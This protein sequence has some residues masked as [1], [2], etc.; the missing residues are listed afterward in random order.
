MSVAREAADLYRRLA[1]ESPARFEHGFALS[2]NNLSVSFA[3]RGDLANSIVSIR[4][5]VD[6]RRRLA[7]ENPARFGSDLVVSLAN[8]E[9]RLR[10]N[11]DEQG[12]EAA[13]REAA[14]FRAQCCGGLH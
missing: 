2:L 13:A 10:D 4:E 11:G 7:L 6:I 8:L 12:A 9:I 14:A 5:A 3:A 1:V